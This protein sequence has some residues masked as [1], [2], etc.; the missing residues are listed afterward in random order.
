[1][2]VQP[3]VRLLA[4]VATPGFIQDAPVLLRTLPRLVLEQGPLLLRELQLPGRGREGEGALERTVAGGL[5][6][7]IVLLSDLAALLSAPSLGEPPPGEAVG[8][9]DPA[10]GLAEAEATPAAVAPISPI[11]SP[12]PTA[13]MRR[14]KPLQSKPPPSKRHPLCLAVH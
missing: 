8:E 3:G 13:T 14:H 9:G 2:V 10:G 6:G 11:C 7:P 5:E 12:N 4:D 1:M